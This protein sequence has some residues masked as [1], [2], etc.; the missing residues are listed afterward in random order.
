MEEINIF[1]EKFKCVKTSD[2]T[3]RCQRANWESK[4]T[5]FNF[6]KY[7]DKIFKTLDGPTTAAKFFGTHYIVTKIDDN[8]YRCVK[9][10]PK[11]SWYGYYATWFQ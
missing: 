6:V 7:D 11:S 8:N 4:Y 5:Y 1:R 3:A 9:S 10:D 2:K